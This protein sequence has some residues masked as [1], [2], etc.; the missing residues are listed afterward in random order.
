MT[1][2][3]KSALTYWDETTQSAR[4]LPNPLKLPDRLFLPHLANVASVA[5]HIL[6]QLARSALPV[7]KSLRRHSSSPLKSVRHSLHTTVSRIVRLTR[8][9][10]LRKRFLDTRSIF[11]T[12]QRHLLRRRHICQYDF[13]RRSISE[14]FGSTALDLLI[15]LVGTE[16]DIEVVVAA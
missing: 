1:S 6:Y 3:T 9:D 14:D 7:E 13:A 5:C 2:Y 8:S 16:N 15:G 11:G 12:E 10:Q 4:D